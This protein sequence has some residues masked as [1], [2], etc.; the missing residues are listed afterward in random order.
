MI[1]RIPHVVIG[2]GISGLGAAHFALRRGVQ[3][4]V[5]EH[6]DRVGGTL[7]SVHF[8]ACPGFWTEAGGHTCYNSYGNLLSILDDLGLIPL[9]RPKG[10]VPFRLWRDG[11]LHSI[12]SA[13]HPLELVVALPR[14]LRSSRA[15]KGLAEYYG[16]T[17]G[18]RNYRDLFRPAFRAVVC[19]PPDDFPAELL[20][21]KKPRREGLPKSFTLPHGLGEIAQAIANQEGLSV[22]L[23]RQ[24]SGVAQVGL[25]LR[26]SLSGGD[27]ILCDALTLAVP[28]DVAAT[29][30]PAE[31][32]EAS[33]LVAGVGVAEIETLV[34][35][36]PAR[37]LEQAKLP[38]LAGLIAVDDAFYSAVSRDYAPDPLWRGFAFHFQPGVMGPADRLQRACQ[39]LGVSTNLVAEVAQVTN[40]LPALRKGHAE[41]VA[42]LDAALAGTRLGVT[43]NWF[44]G[45][46]IED[47]LSRS[48]Q[49][50]DRLFPA[51]TDSQGGRPT[52]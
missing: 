18:L 5:L 16:E 19:Q 20:F 29:L 44:I 23:N 49:E 12:F 41:L 3:T 25:G 34:L 31:L 28:P 8:D 50:V 38:P 47:C 45:V 37:D 39:A 1:E 52:T 33:A 21:R 48:R 22:R 14:L 6:S 46:S 32:P 15:G 17:F 11:K 36:V 2:G 27:E 35:A 7:N 51:P 40:R 9:L 4:L 24:V 13:L 10:K 43:G 42:K 26:I 30:I